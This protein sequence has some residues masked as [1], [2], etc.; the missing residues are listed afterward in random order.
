MSCSPLSQHKGRCPASS[1]D[2]DCTSPKSSKKVIPIIP[3]AHG[4]TFITFPCQH[5][6]PSGHVGE[7]CRWAYS[8]RPSRWSRDGNGSSSFMEGKGVNYS[9]G[10]N[11]NL[12][13]LNIPSTV[14]F[15]LLPA[16]FSHTFF[17]PHHA[18]YFSLH[19]ARAGG[20]WAFCTREQRGRT[21]ECTFPCTSRP[22]SLGCQTAAIN[23][24]NII[25]RD[26]ASY[27]QSQ[28]EIHST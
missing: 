21:W 15:P 28:C 23:N 1:L 13:S 18:L 19:Q 5:P 2:W 16:P 6:Q 10:V 22:S 24:Q 12:T 4:E 26:N 7:K 27:C 3:L 14:P 9:P 8:Q 11:T 17:L 25:L 20:P